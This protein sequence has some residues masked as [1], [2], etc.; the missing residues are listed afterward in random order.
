MDRTRH[1]WKLK[2]CTLLAALALSAPFCGCLANAISG[3]MYVMDPNDKKAEFTGLKGKRV[4]VVC[5]PPADLKFS[6]AGVSSELARAVGANLQQN[7]A[8]IEVID[9]QEVAQWTDEHTLEDF[10]QIG[11]ALKADMVVGIDLDSFSLYQEQTLYQGRANYH[12]KVYELLKDSAATVVYDKIPSPSVYPTNTGV[13]TLERQE[14]QFRR[15]YIASLSVEIARHF[16]AYESRFHF[17][18]DSDAFRRAP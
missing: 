9:P 7:V 5:R 11:K 18:G 12:I 15:E 2:F 17:A 1:G 4:A 13:S 14:A 10:V 6:Y 16:Y 3:L 8:K